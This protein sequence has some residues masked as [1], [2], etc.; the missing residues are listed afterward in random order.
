MCK[1]SQLKLPKTKEANLLD[2]DSSENKDRNWVLLAG[3]CDKTLLRNKIGFFTASLFNGIEGNENLYIPHSEF[4]DVVLNGEYLGNYCLT[5]SVKEGSERLAVNEEA[6]DDGGIGFVAEYD[7]G[8]YASEPKYFKS[9]KKQYPYTFKFPKTDDT[10]FDSYMEYF[11]ENINKFESALYDSDSED[12]W[13]KYIDVESFA[14]WFLAHNIIANLDT[15][16]F[17]SK[18]T[19]DD[20]SKLVMGPVWDFEWSIGIGWYYKSRPRPADY[21]C[22]NGWYF[23]ELLKKAEFV[24]EVKSQWEKLTSYL[25]LAG[26]IDGKM[27]EYAE[28]IAISQKINFIRW[29]ILGEQISVGGIPLGS[30]EA[31]LEYDKQFIVNR[32]PW[33]DSA[34]NELSADNN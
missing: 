21:W 33:L 27:D 12:D 4:V 13:Q 16:Y 24:E 11:E 1:Q 15:N 2:T 25:D 7:P 9:A 23:A 10:D 18:K 20:S 8:Y 19:S 22:V 5:D 6:T 30:Y 34:I 17:F 28:S 29:D 32:I 3:Y 26:T 31:E 14:R